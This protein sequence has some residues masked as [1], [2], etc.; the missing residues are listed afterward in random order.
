MESTG[1]IA[2]GSGGA[3]QTTRKDVEKLLFEMNRWSPD[4]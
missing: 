2:L 4:I 3:G 1:G